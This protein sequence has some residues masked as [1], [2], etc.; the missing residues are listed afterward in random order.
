MCERSSQ[1]DSWKG[2]DR[3]LPLPSCT[4]RQQFSGSISL[5]LSLWL[6]CLRTS[7]TKVVPQTFGQKLRSKEAGHNKQPQ[8]QLL[9]TKTLSL[10]P[11]L[12]LSCPP[13]LASPFKSPAL[14]FRSSLRRFPL[15]GFMLPLLS[16]ALFISKRMRER[17]S[18]DEEAEQSGRGLERRRERLPFSCITSGAGSL[19]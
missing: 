7:G 14:P 1:G 15:D 3:S 17:K 13:S 9:R 4:R 18:R 10:L 6:S 19:S 16:A 2:V 12:S 11:S 5:S 8:T